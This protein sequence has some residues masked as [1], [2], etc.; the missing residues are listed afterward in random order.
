M[1]LF[2]TLFLQ[3]ITAKTQYLY[4]AISESLINTYLNLAS[5]DAFKDVFLQI[6]IYGCLFHLPN[7]FGQ[8]LTHSFISNPEI[9]KFTCLLNALPFLL[10]SLISP[11]SSLIATPSLDGSEALMVKKYWLTHISPENFLL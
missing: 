4:R 11:T 10:A 9:P 3:Y 1:E 8:L 6:H 2:I 7:L 5:S